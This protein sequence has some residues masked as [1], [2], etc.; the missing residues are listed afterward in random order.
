[1]ATRAKR[2]LEKL[3]LIYEE[4]LRGTTTQGTGRFPHTHEAEWD[5]ETGSGRTIS[6]AGKGPKHEHVVKDFKVLC[7]GV[8][9][10]EH[11]SD[12]TKD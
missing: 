9:K 12:L 4:V 5:S 1:M 10:H 8:D 3:R 6:T 2:L 11:P 7:G